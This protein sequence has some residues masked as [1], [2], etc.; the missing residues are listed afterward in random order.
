MTEPI[1][2]DL[3]ELLEPEAFEHAAGR[4]RA[5]MA[6]LDAAEWRNMPD[7]LLDSKISAKVQEAA[8]DVDIL[9]LFAQGWAK[10]AEIRSHADT[11]KYPANKTSFV[12]IG[13]VEQ[14]QDVNVETT[15]HC[16]ALST[17][18]V[19]F[20]L[21]F[22]ARFDAVEIA[23][24]NK[25]IE[26]IGGGTCELSVMLK[27]DDVPLWPDKKV[28]TFDLPGNYPFEAPG[29]PIAAR[30]PSPESETS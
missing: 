26:R 27:Y 4:V 9:T 14:N 6:Q 21:S 10:A 17:P 28:K 8:A 16:G 5:E 7:S 13:T 1:T 12:K 22:S 25:H 30:Q 11:E 18:P 3:N 29:I 23:I 20:R 19:A 2:I 24:R 15:I